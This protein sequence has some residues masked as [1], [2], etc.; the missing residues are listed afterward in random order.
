MR[1]LGSNRRRGAM[2]GAAI[3]IV[4]LMGLG[5]A[6]PLAGA[7]AGGGGPGGARASPAMPCC[8]SGGGTDYE[9]TFTETGLP[10]NT[11]WWVD[12]S[13]WNMTNFLPP[14]EVYLDEPNGTYTYTIG[15]AAG[16]GPD[17]ESGSLV[18]DGAAVNRTVVFTPIEYEAQFSETGLAV[19]TY[20][21]VQ[22][23]AST[24]AS[25][26]SSIG[27]DEP[28]GTY[29]FSIT[30][31]APQYYVVGASIKGNVTF[32]TAATGNVTLDGSGAVVNVEFAD[33]VYAVTLKETG[34]PKD[35]GWIAS[36]TGS[37]GLQENGTMTS[38]LGF[39][40]PN[41]TYTWRVLA[42]PAGYLPETT[43]GSVTVDGSAVTVDV[44]FE[45]LKYAVAF[46][47]SGLP[48]GTSWS[49]TLN[50]TKT[51]SK[52]AW[53]NFTVAN[54]TGSGYAFTVGKVT[55][56]TSA[57]SSGTLTVSGAAV[58]KAIAFHAAP[59]YN[60]TFDALGLAPGTAWTT[61]FNG[62]TITSSAERHVYHVQNYTPYPFLAS[63]SY[64]NN[65]TPSSG[66]VTV[67]G[68]PVTVSITFTHSVTFVETGLP[69][70]TNWTVTVN[71]SLHWSTNTTIVLWGY[72]NGSVP[73]TVGSIADYQANASS[74]SAEVQGAPV[75]VAIRFT[76]VLF[77]VVFEEAGLVSGTTWAVT[78]NGTR[79]T[80]TTTTITF[81]VPSGTYAYQIGE[82][83]TYNLTSAEYGNVTVAGAAPTP[84]QVTYVLAE[85][86]MTFTETG[87]P[88][89][90]TWSV[91][92]GGKT[93]ANSASSRIVFL[94]TG[95]GSFAYNVSASAELA[96]YPSAGSLAAGHNLSVTIG[97]AYEVSFTGS[98]SG[99]TWSM[100]IGG[101]TQSTV[102]KI[103]FLE[104]NA[105]VAW[106]AGTE[107]GTYDSRSCTIAADPNSGS[108]TVSGSAVSV[109]VS[110]PVPSSSTCPTGG[111]CLPTLAAMEM[112]IDA[113][114]QNVL[115]LGTGAL[116]PIEAPA[117]AVLVGVGLAV[118]AYQLRDPRDPR[119]RRPGA[120]GA[121]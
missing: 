51:T 25:E 9:I 118:T 93:V 43:S 56:F 81:S 106:T 96:V 97:Y 18:I 34:L 33:T 4:L 78:L 28:V 32:A 49:V 89:G 27:L 15:A 71:G 54:S 72:A 50:G 76:Q 23:G 88:S 8:P 121:D 92:L 116:G 90:A 107:T 109:T 31:G 98:E 52:T 46:E 94:E 22:L 100:S 59:A 80:S 42:G 64:G 105:T 7:S 86:P 110:Y 75:S 20:W 38:S 21:S 120:G 40:E 65:A 61:T 114:P 102:G 103:V 57:P 16:W 68:A 53:V 17:P 3:G 48:S 60:V 82:V 2:V 19:G 117:F 95:S 37:D 101:L 58:V 85:Y 62:T 84:I 6:L 113:R 77:P 45:H 91:E 99:W 5:G 10:A 79:E 35:D 39:F 29:G 30:S 63:S 44:T 11:T 73:Y 112:C 87:L 14:D 1:A 36:L 55:N 119:A 70:G 67:N 41:G 74:G 66:D 26:T 69:L 13:G 83:L 104:P 108:V 47:E 115:S 24:V 12:V 111:G